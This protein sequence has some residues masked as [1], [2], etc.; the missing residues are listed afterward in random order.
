VLVVKASADH[1]VDA[2]FERVHD[3]SDC[4]TDRWTNLPLLF[5]RQ[6]Q[7]TLIEIFFDWQ[8]HRWQNALNVQ[9]I[10]VDR[11]KC[12]TSRSSSLVNHWKWPR[13]IHLFITLV[14][15]RVIS[16]KIRRHCCSPCPP[17]SHEHYLSSR[18]FDWCHLSFATIHRSEC[19]KSSTQLAP[20]D[21]AVD[22]ESSSSHSS[23]SLSRSFVF[24]A[25][26]QEP[27]ARSCDRHVDISRWLNVVDDS[28]GIFAPLLVAELSTMD[29]ETSTQNTKIKRA[30]KSA[31]E[32]NF[33]FLFFCRLRLFSNY[34]ET[35]DDE[36]KKEYVPC[37]SA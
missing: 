12:S 25:R 33:L 14:K 6:R 15:D 23:L 1:R 29:R 18:H 21:A 27:T 26:P 37:S 17:V 7:S 31:E 28:V 13:N 10:I 4:Q 22:D 32:R 30:K 36:E 3:Y 20:V 2:F 16:A 9:S 35:R 5:F 11:D 34:W 8:C 24:F 19:V